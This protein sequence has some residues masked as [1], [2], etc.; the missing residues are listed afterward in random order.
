MSILHKVVLLNLLIIPFSLC[1]QWTQVGSDIDGQTPGERYGNSVAL[2]SDGSIMAAGGNFNDV[3]ANNAG[4]VSAYSWNGVAWSQLG[5]NLYGEAADDEFGYSIGLSTDGTTMAIGAPFNDGT[6]SAAGHVQVYSWNGASWTQMGSDIDGEAANDL[7]GYNLGLSGDGSRV[8]IGAYGNDGGGSFTGHVRVYSWNGASWV[9]MGSDI[10]GEA[11]DDYSGVA[12][13]ISTD[14][15]TVAIGADGNDGAAS[16]AGHVRVYSWNGASWT[17]VGSD[18]DGEAMSDRSGSS[19]SLSSD[20]RRIAIGATQND[21][22]AMSSGHV[23]VY[24]WLVGSWTQLGL[25]IDGEASFDLSGTS[26]SLS[27]V[28]NI[29]AIGA[30]N[31]GSFFGHVRVYIWNGVVWSQIDSDIDGEAN[32]DFS[33]QSVSLSS[34]GGYVAIGAYRNFG[35]GFESGHVRVYQNITILPLTITDFSGN[36]NHDQ[37]ILNWVAHN[38][39]TNQYFEIERSGNQQFFEKIGLV[40]GNGRINTQ[41]HYQ[42]VDEAPYIGENYYRVRI[43][44]AKN[45]QATYSDIIQI[46]RNATNNT[47]SIIE[48]NNYYLTLISSTEVLK[49]CIY[50]IAGAKIKERDE[51]INNRGEWSVDIGW[52]RPGGYFIEIFTSNGCVAL[53][54]I[55]AK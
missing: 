47:T 2:S 5:S 38:Q 43:V 45:D 37:A 26:V 39:Q 1:A 9:Q 34:N 35:T 19:V 11:I 28:G 25:D 10:D 44:N 27:S 30:P 55:K 20:G 15:S 7:S 23:R 41:A 46:A 12:V 22:T 50:N 17:Q 3:S 32:T 31:N 14:G 54:F 21:G 49:Y 36:I 24:E 42:F 13:D 29:L 48:N 6:A 16:L 51:S 33:G 52:L 18:I 53:P 40:Y 4:V 8:A